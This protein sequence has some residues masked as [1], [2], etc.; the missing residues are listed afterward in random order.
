MR[1]LHFD[2]TGE[3]RW[4][5]FKKD[6]IPPYAILSHTWG[7]DEVT[8]EDL[9]NKTAEQKI[10]YEKI[11]FCGQ[12]VVRD[13]LQYFWVDT[14]CIDKRNLS[15][16]SRSINS[17][18]R[19]YQ[20][21][22][23]CYAFLSDVSTFGLRNLQRQR[24]RWE[25]NF[26]SSRWF[27]RGWTLQEL[28]APTTVEFFSSQ[29]HLLGDKISMEQLIHEITNIPVEALKGSPLQNFSNADRMTWAKNRQTT[30]EED[31]AYCLLGIFGVF[32]PLIYGEG[33]SNAMN[34]LRE[35][36]NKANFSTDLGVPQEYNR[37]CKLMIHEVKYV[38]IL[39]VFVP[40]RNENFV[41]RSNILENIKHQLDPS[42]SGNSTTS[43]SRL[44]LFG[45][46]GV[47]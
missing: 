33:K 17:M 15:E 14:C 26:R 32:L 3:L 30:E 8:Y 16:V 5:V 39:L 43:Q 10:G 42:L 21:A 6:A 45:L 24:N 9:I 38:L 34:R 27:T 22:V 23:K 20:N 18:F 12:Q 19:W 28:I 13:G 35:Q 47:G 46:G 37:S 2:E 11:Q 29:S 44:A 25:S 1:L 4:T 7:D 36:I 41:G 40:E 31:S